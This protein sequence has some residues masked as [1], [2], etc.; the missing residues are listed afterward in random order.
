[1]SLDKG[2]YVEENFPAFT[3][4]LYNNFKHRTAKCR[5]MVKDAMEKGDIQPKDPIASV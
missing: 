2:T 5:E 3:K 4:E 1:M